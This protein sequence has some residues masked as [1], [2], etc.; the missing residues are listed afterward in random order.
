MK[1]RK[2]DATQNS[3]KNKKRTRSEE[4]A[5]E[6]APTDRT[7]TGED[8]KNTVANLE[9]GKEKNKGKKELQMQ[10]QTTAREGQVRIEDGETRN[11]I[12]AIARKTL[13]DGFDE[14]ERRPSCPYCKASQQIAQP[15]GKEWKCTVDSCKK[16]WKKK[17]DVI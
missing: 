4:G 9:Q 16:Y 10:A 7:R 3:T 12:A 2:A 5:A 8:L 6:E 1:R 11:D 15:N 13:R 17:R 14:K